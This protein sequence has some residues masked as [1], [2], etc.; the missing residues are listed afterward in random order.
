M[1]SSPGSLLGRE[2]SPTPG[3]CIS[4]AERAPFQDAFRL[5]SLGNTHV[6]V[7]W[8][9]SCNTQRLVLVLMDTD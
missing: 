7:Y 8:V 1:K 2:G 3:K 9:S 6:L 5:V 4:R